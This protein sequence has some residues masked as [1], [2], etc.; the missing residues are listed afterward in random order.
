MLFWNLK[1]ARHITG[2]QQNLPGLSAKTRALGLG[3]VREPPQ[4]RNHLK[5]VTAVWKSEVGVENVDPKNATL[6]QSD[7]I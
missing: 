5:H 6:F 2:F 3:L 7:P 1:T 4:R